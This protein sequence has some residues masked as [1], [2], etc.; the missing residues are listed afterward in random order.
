MKEYL[1]FNL[2][3]YVWIRL[4]DEGKK[5][6]N[7]AYC[8]NYYERLIKPKEDENGWY[9]CQL[10]VVMSDFGEHLYNGCRPPFELTIRIPK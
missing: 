10:W 1:E 6:L 2:N 3:N 5:I 8:K 4:T 9:K 7:K